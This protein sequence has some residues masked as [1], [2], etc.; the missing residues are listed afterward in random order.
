MLLTND[1]L[2]GDGVIVGVLVVVIGGSGLLPLLPGVVGL[3]VVV[4]G[5]LLLGVVVV[6]GLLGEDAAVDGRAGGVRSHRRHSPRLLGGVVLVGGLDDALLDRDLGSHRLG[7]LHLDGAGNLD[8]DGLHDG[9][10]DLDGNRVHLHDGAGLL[11]GVGAGLHGGN[12]RQRPR[13]KVQRWVS[14]VV[15]MRQARGKDG[16]EE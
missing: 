6:G 3:G 2:S 10:G 8:L 9:A 16:W 7:H 11:H 15:A 12:L 13:I 14:W 5:G 1:S 4:V